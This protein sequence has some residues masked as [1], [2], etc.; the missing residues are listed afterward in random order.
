MKISQFEVWIADLNPRLGTETGKV[1]PVVIIQTDILN[2]VHPSTIICPI[3]TNVQPQSDILRVH[4]KTGMARLKQDCDILLDQ[5]RVIDIKRLQRRLG[6]LPDDVEDKIKH[7]LAIILD[8]QSH[9][10]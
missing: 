10:S 5:I 4:L 6:S 8:L 1:R 2:S 7:N 9:N 3:T